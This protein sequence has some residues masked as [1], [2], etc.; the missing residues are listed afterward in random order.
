MEA[1]PVRPP[2]PRPKKKKKVTGEYIWFDAE[3]NWG[4]G[5]EVFAFDGTVFGP[6]DDGTHDIEG[7]LS[8]EVLNGTIV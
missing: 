4:T 2:K 6:L 3:D 5:T 7:E 1:G 8:V